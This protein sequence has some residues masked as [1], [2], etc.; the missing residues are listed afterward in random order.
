VSGFWKKSKIQGTSSLREMS[1]E[2]QLEG[3][4]KARTLRT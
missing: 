1:E 4:R 2:P 3:A